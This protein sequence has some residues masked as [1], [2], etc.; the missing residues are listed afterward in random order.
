MRA[1]PPPALPA[2]LLAVDVIAYTAPHPWNEIRS[3]A[4]TAALPL[5]L[6][7]LTALLPVAWTA[8]RSGISITVAVKAAPPDNAP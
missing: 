1:I 5:A 2:L 4:Q 6:T 7:V 3:T 8:I